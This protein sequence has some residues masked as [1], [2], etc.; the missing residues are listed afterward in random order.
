MSQGFQNKTTNFKNT[1]F[2]YGLALGTFALTLI[3]AL[4][5]QYYSIK[6]NLIF[7]VVVALIIPSWFGGRGPGLL[8]AIL[9]IL[10]SIFTNLKPA[11]MPLFNYILS[12]FSGLFF[13]VVVVLLVSSRRNFEINLRQQREL[14]QTTLA[15]IGDAVIAT[16]IDGKIN[17]INPVAETLTGWTFKEA[18]GKP[19]D[20]IFIIINEHTRQT[21]ENPVTQVL[22]EKKVV[23]LDFET[24]L[25]ARDG[26]EIPIDDSAA[27][28]KAAKGTIIGVVLAFRDISERKQLIESDKRLQQSQKMEAIGTLTGGV[29]HD[30]NNLLTA[31]LGNTQ[32]ALLKI[33]AEDPVHKHL[34][35]IEE[36]GKRATVLTR[37]LLAFSRQQRLE[38]RN[39]N[40]N[41]TIGEIFQLLKRIIGEDVEVLTKY[42]DNLSMV[43]IDPAQ[44]E[45]VIMNLAVNARDAMPGGG[46]LT[47]ETG[48]IELDESYSRRYPYVQPGK[49]VQITVSDT[50]SGMDEAT[51]EHIFEPFFT[52]KEIGKGT[53]LGLSMAYGIIKQHNGN[54]NVYS[55]VGHGTIFKIFL[56]AVE[57][58]HEQGEK[59]VVKPILAGGKET[60]LIAEDEEILQ[61]LAVD[62]LE[63]LGYTVLIAKNGKEAVEIYKKNREKIDLL[64]FDVVMPVLGGADAFEQISATGEQNPPVI[65][66]TGYS[67]EM[68]ENR[69][70]KQNQF[71]ETVAATVIQKPYT[72][73]GLGRKVREILDSKKN[74]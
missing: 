10:F 45:Q 61:N 9:L 51:Q 11:E 60:I 5:L 25:I 31:I 15:S 21:I 38:R 63:G 50:G 59:N 18:K 26:R 74:K 12:F 49:Y 8:V 20:E 14:W 16:D 29:A 24:L 55:E 47:L 42:A 43:Q 30:F 27:P 69:L 65:F 32:L 71:V 52:T 53:G 46:Q 13:C 44:I 67:S 17:F 68:V 70:V 35:E 48:N 37:Q 3:I 62:I 66:M 41:E 39:A 22:R 19:L 1:A 54:I 33:F 40:L 4:L 72:I 6:L 34:K 58:I 28:I 36:A 7:L 73:D 23:E 64:L 56:P 57:E 2:R